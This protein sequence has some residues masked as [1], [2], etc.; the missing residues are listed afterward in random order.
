MANLDLSKYGILNSIPVVHNPSYEELFQAEMSPDNQGFE[1]GVLTNTGAVS[2][3]TGK[4]TG[5]SPKDRF[6][7]KDAVSDQHMWWDGNINKPV[8]TEV[9]HD[10]KANTLAELNKAKKLYV[11][12]TFCG[13][14]E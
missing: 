4:F 8:S 3:D 14:N 1:K 9:W 6:I 13:T 12:D 10:L 11:V 2:V 7:V 5:R